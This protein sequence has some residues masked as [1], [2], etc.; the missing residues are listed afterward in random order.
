MRK[1]K[2]TSLLLFLSS[3]KLE[4]PLCGD[5]QYPGGGQGQDGAKIFVG[6]KPTKILVSLAAASSNLITEFSHKLKYFGRL[7][8]NF[9]FDLNNIY[10]N[11]YK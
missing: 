10:G 4:T 6:M 9:S 8:D 7:K 2:K 3:F 1:N 5:I 11:Y